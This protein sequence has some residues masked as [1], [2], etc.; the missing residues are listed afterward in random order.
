MLS[1]CGHEGD[2]RTLLVI[3]EI[4]FEPLLLLLGHRGFFCALGILWEK[5]VSHHLTT[6]S[7]KEARRTTF[8]SQLA[9]TDLR[10]A[11]GTPQNQGQDTRIVHETLTCPAPS[12]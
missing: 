8:H 11:D 7:R 10:G 5:A 2:E 12:A 1:H 4:L 9:W 3:L 6:R